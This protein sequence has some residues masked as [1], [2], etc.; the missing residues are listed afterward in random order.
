MNNQDNPMGWFSR[1]PTA[2][3]ILSLIAV[4]VILGQIFNT[5]DQTSKEISPTLASSDSVVEASATPPVKDISKK[6]TVSKPSV[7]SDNP[8][9]DSDPSTSTVTATS[10]PTLPITTTAPVE[11]S[12]IVPSIASTPDFS[13][14]SEIHL[15][16]Y[17]N[18]PAAYQNKGMKT[19]SVII[20]D[21][22]PA[23]GRG[24]NSNYIALAD[25]HLGLPFQT[26]AYLRIDNSADYKK[27]TNKLSRN[28]VINIYGTGKAS[29]Q[30]SSPNGQ[31][32]AYPIIAPQRIDKCDTNAALVCKS[33]DIQTIWP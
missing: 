20:T 11:T 8:V 33:G 15:E 13:T 23:G 18:N 6:P 2:T 32:V 4:F 27:I 17:A 9:K 25:A 16:D 10:S 30:F 14:Y 5:A 22:L 28:D 3:M 29:E 19:I 26:M 21:F 12:P 24:G 7:P 1:H 31:S